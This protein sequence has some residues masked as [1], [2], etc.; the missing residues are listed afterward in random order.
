ME[1]VPPL[2]LLPENTFLSKQPHRRNQVPLIKLVLLNAFHFPPKPS[3]PF[4]NKRDRSIESRIIM[5][6]QNETNGPANDLVAEPKPRSSRLLFGILFLLCAVMG[7]ITLRVNSQRFTKKWVEDLGGSVVYHIERGEKNE[8][9]TPEEMKAKPGGFMLNVVGID[10]VSAIKEVNLPDGEITEVDPLS[11]LAE[12]KTVRILPN[13]ITSLK[14]LE[15]YKTLERLEISD[16]PIS[17]LSPI[18]L[19]TG[20]RI[21]QL[22]GT[23]VDSISC[24]S[25]FKNLVR[26]DLINTAV[27]D[28]SPLRDHTTIKTL[29]VTNAE[30]TDLAPLENLTNLKLLSL[31]GCASLDSDDFSIALDPISKLEIESLDLSGT[32]LNNLSVLTGLTKLETLKLDNSTAI[33]ITPLGKLKTL[34]SLTTWDSGV[35]AEA[36]AELKEQIPGL[37]I[38]T[39]EPRY[40]R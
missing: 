5:T 1:S 21:F 38:I 9:L 12:V 17:D 37:L 18:A 24:L 4:V 22:S 15:Q 25:D 13:K 6:D 35:S 30:L 8:S 11:R 36:V 7:V 34:K 28:L 10:Y 27:K 39:E 40:S 2:L 3:R 31:A 16:N 14:P 20:L 32:K 29:K 26:I 33:D 23:K 19:N